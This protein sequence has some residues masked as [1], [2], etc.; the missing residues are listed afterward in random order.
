MDK[1]TGRC[2]EHVVPKGTG[3]E[4]YPYINIIRP[5]GKQ[6]RIDTIGE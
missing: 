4:K 2:K 6:V 1:E 5:D 3:H